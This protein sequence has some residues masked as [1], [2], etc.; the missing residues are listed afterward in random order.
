MERG[1][2]LGAGEHAVSFPVAEFLPVRDGRRALVDVCPSGNAGFAGTPDAP[3][4]FLFP[5]PVAPEEIALEIQFFPGFRVDELVD[6]LVADPHPRVGR[7]FFFDH[8][9]NDVRAPSLRRQSV[10][11]VF[12]YLRILQWGFPS[13]PF[14]PSP[15]LVSCRIRKII[16]IFG[17][18]VLLGVLPFDGRLVPV[19][20]SGKGS[21][22]PSESGSY[23][24]LKRSRRQELENNFPFIVGNMSILVH[25]NGGLKY[26]T[27]LSY[28][29][30]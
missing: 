30:F 5:L 25:G 10:D 6:V 4:G 16:I 28:R 13:L 20:F 27:Y 22:A 12:E 23:F 2:R 29:F 21:F 26:Y 7:M 1:S 17:G 24:F 9:G 3:S 15:G 11:D 19:E 14:P 8:F 18:F